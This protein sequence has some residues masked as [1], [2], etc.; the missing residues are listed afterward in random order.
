MQAGSRE[1]FGIFFLEQNKFDGKLDMNQYLLLNTH[2]RNLVSNVIN[3]Q[4]I[5]SL[6]RSN[7]L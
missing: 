3:T 7:K 6:F 2:R 1:H 4:T 5:F